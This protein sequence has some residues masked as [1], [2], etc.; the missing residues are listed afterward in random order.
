MSRCIFIST[1]LTYQ[2]LVTC[3]QTWYYYSRYPSDP[4]YI[5]FL[6]SLSFFLSFGAVTILR[7]RWLAFFCQ[8]VATRP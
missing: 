3:I 1:P 5:K 8:T 7:H 4:W 6:V 2:T